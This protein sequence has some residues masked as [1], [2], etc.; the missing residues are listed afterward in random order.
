MMYRAKACYV[1]RGVSDAHYKLYTLAQRFNIGRD[2][3]RGSQMQRKVGRNYLMG[4]RMS[5]N[6]QTVPF[7]KMI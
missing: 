6:I 4:E 5:L 2:L 3:N 1:F 7:F